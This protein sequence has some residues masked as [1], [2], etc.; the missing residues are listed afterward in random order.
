MSK[1]AP[2][3]ALVLSAAAGCGA[4]QLAEPPEVTAPPTTATETHGPARVYG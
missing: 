4:P 3:V 2:L 1:R